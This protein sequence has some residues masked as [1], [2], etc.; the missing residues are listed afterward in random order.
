MPDRAT[1]ERIHWALELL[2]VR[3]DDDVLEVG[4]GVGAAVEL[5]AARLTSGGA[6]AAIDRSAVMVAR[7]RARNATAIGAGQVRIARQTLAEAAE[8]GTA[9]AKVFAVNVNAFWADPVPSGAALARL[10][11]AGGTTHLVYELPDAARLGAL[12]AALPAALEAAGFRV[13]DVLVTAGI[14]RPRIAVIA[15]RP[16]RAGTRAD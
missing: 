14:R 10:V 7:A 4:C 8:S 12:E 16:A 15:R 3:P 2:N 6:I 5:V 11:R 9:Y 13:S 1:P